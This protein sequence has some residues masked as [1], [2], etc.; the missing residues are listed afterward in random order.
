MK[1][2]IKKA[3]S[4]TAKHVMEKSVRSRVKIDSLKTSG[5]EAS[6]GKVGNLTRVPTS[7]TKGKRN[8]KKR[9]K[10]RDSRTGFSGRKILSKP[11]ALEV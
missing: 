11:C 10:P 3:N 4:I 7:G 2:A 6:G 9:E 8:R 1:K 5:K